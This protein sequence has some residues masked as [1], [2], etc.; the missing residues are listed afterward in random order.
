[1]IT[2]KNMATACAIACGLTLQATNAA[3][4]ITPVADIGNVASPVFD[5]SIDVPRD[6]GPAPWYTS[7]NLLN[8][9]NV[10]VGVAELP[11]APNGTSFS[12]TG[13]QLYD[14]SGGFKFPGT[15]N[16]EHNPFSEPVKYIIADLGHHPWGE[17]GVPLDAGKYLIG[18]SGTGDRYNNYFGNYTDYPDFRI[19]IR[20]MP[21]PEP[22]TYALMLA[23]LGLVGFM[24]RRRTLAS[25]SASHSA[26]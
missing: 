12:V 26:G 25:P 9:A 5:Q 11:T 6:K 15:D 8:D 17:Q 19:H 3:A 13:A 22:E 18:V 1:M 21:V 10:T 24:A 16:V 14:G 20:V 23:G 2:L 7:F 4:E